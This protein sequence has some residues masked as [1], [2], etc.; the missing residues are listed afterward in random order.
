MNQNTTSVVS[1]SWRGARITA[2]NV[3]HRDEDGETILHY[4]C[5]KDKPRLVRNVLEMGADINLATPYGNTPLE[6]VVRCPAFVECS[7]ILIDHR[8]V[9]IRYMSEYESRVIRVILQ[10]F[11]SCRLA[12]LAVAGLSLTC[13]LKHVRR[14][15]V[16]VMRLVAK[17]VWSTR[18]DDEWEE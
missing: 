1:L 16:N 5:R 14:Q 9:E 8:A 7:R 15:D 17:H 10:A 18:F 13:P 11:A 2:D 12:S 3:N 4:A 6:L